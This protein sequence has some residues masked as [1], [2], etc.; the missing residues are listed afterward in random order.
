MDHL[1][2][3]KEYNNILPLHAVS[4]LIKFINTVE[5]NVASVINDTKEDKTEVNTKVRNTESYALH[6]HSPSMTNVHYWN[7][8]SSTFAN[9]INKYRDDC[10]ANAHEPIKFINDITILKYK[11]GG[12]YV[13][14][15]DHNAEIPRTV[16]IIYLLNNDY[17][18]GDLVFVDPMDYSKTLKRVKTEPN[19]LII[20]PSNFMYPHGVENV[21][22]GL[23]YSIV[24]W[25]L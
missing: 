19:K 2:F 17:K 24:S 22:E 15:I 25:A 20:W 14:H 8:L 21:E 11:T 4:S 16:S 13:P 9:I 3:I 23:R 18:G 7:L 6:S 12:F 5:F 1:S 10:F